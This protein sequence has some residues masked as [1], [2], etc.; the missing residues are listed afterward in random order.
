[1][2]LNPGN[3]TI[4]CFA[5]SIFIL[6]SITAVFAIPLTPMSVQG[7]VTIDGNPAPAGTAVT[8]EMEGELVDSYTVQSTGQ[9]MLTIPGESTDADK[10]IEFF[11][12]GDRTDVTWNWESGAIVTID[13]TISTAESSDTPSS[14]ASS[15]YSS[16][17]SDTERPSEDPAS[18]ESSSDEHSETETVADE[19]EIM[20]DNGPGTSETA[21]NPSSSNPIPGFSSFTVIIGLIILCIGANRNKKE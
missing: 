8:A 11:V 14:S 18:E 12:N 13:L 1:M 3:K 10:L 17:N 21:D 7:D 19:P 9:Y 2:V 4:V 20:P 16:F 6:M 15:S 5:T